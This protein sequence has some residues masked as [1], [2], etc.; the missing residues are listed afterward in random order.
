M[1]SLEQSMHAVVLVK[2]G[3]VWGSGVMVDRS[4]GIIITCYHVIKSAKENKG[5][6][7]S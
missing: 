6:Y 5:L 7:T 3:T 1:R 4:E 2:V